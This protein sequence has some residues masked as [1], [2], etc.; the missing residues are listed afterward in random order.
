MQDA[1]S[2]GNN[3]SFNDQGNAAP[4]DGSHSGLVNIANNHASSMSVELPSITLPKGGGAISGIEEKFQVNAAKGNASFSIPIPLSPA[5][6]SPGV[7]LGYNSSAGN[8]PFGLGWQ[9]AIAS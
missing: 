1:N 6:L 8:S 4:Q 7:A 3:Y 5:R 2:I 9:L